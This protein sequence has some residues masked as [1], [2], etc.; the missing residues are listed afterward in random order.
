MVPYSGLVSED[1]AVFKALAD[2]TRRALLDLLHT[3]DGRTLG[4]LCAGIDMSRQAV[5]KH[6][7]VLEQAGLVTTRRVGRTKEHH[8][9]AAPIQAIYERWIAKY[10]RAPA[11]A[12]HGLK[13]AL[14]ERT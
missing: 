2:G 13:Q 12:L 10:E 11:A 8:L 3:S 9:N 4:Q 7:R 14:E 5:A 6:L 1:E